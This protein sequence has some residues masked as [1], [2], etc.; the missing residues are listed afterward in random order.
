[1]KSEK[2]DHIH[3]KVDDMKSVTQA[4]A[5]V[6]GEK[7]Q[8]E[9]IDFTADSGLKV[10]F[11]QFPNGIEIMEVTD[12]TKEMAALYD[13]AP[14][15]VFAISLKVENIDEATTDMESMGHKMLMRYGFGEVKEALFDTKK[16]L[17]VYVELVEYPTDSIFSSVSEGTGK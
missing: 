8:M 5:G 14:Q 1:M 11:N 17:G 12:N 15:G 16:A 3:I 13:Q 10:S 6:L 2:L 9:E 7:M 4:F